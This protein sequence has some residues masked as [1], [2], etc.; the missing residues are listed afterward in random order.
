MKEKEPTKLTDKKQGVT[1]ANVGA[2]QSACP[3][4]TRN[5]PHC[6]CHNDFIL[7]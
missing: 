6:P 2:G 1:T 3:S 4:R 5:H 7:L